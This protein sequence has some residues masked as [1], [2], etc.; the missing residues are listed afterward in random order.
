[1]PDRPTAPRAARARLLCGALS[2]ASLW[3]ILLLT[4]APTG[5]SGPSGFQ[6]RFLRGD[7]D[8]SDI[9]CNVLLFVPFAA[10]LRCSGVGAWRTIALGCAVSATVEFLQLRVIPGRDSALSDLMSN[11]L[12]AALGAG[13]AGW[14]PTRRRTVAAGIWAAGAGITIIAVTGLLRQSSFPSS[15]YFGQWTANL[16]MYEWYRGRVLSARI[17]E[18]P[19]PS[20]RLDDSRTVRARLLEGS[21]VVV[22]ALAGPR[23]AGVAP[24][25]SIFDGEH[26]EVLLVGPDR[27][28]LVLHVRSRAAALL[29]RPAEFRWPRALAGVSPG[30][31]LAVTVR[32][33]P[34]GYCLALNGLERCGLA[35]TAGEAWS[36]FQSLPGLSPGAQAVLAFVT[37]FLLGLPV[38][39]VTVA[40]GR[41]WFGPAL[42]LGGSLGVPLLVGLAPTPP[43]QVA[44]LALGLAAGALT[45]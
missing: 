16:G 8:L 18:V 34:S 26:R 20:W 5:G 13:L 9:L 43:L 3:A 4:L 31:S 14:L 28:D 11:T 29:L 32:R 7:L 37:M 10:A 36:L 44:G 35:H 17:A 6:W 23:T 38:G 25:F 15:H 1:M 21:P 39:L 30:D 12:G 40:K 19:L 42:V 41:G 27:D 2:A 22:R 33:E 24:L 45:P